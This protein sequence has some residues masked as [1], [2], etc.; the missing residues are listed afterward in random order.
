MGSI[1]KVGLEVEGG[2][3]GIPGINPFDD[4]ALVA[5]RSID[6][7]TL[8]A[9]HPLLALAHVGEAVSEPLPA[10]QEVI[11]KWIDKYW[12]TAA[13]NTCGYHIHI[14]L[15]SAGNYMRLTS[16]AFLYSL[17][18]KMK[19]IG[20][21]EGLPKTHYL[22]RRLNGANPFSMHHF[23]CSSQIRMARK[24]VGDRTR[25]GTLNFAWKIHGTV[26]FRA[27]P[28]FESKGLAKVFT[29]EYLEFVE[30][31][32]IENKNLFTETYSA[33]LHNRAG[34][35]GMSIGTEEVR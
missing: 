18:E 4:L 32:L 5:D 19:E 24:S 27:L 30:G 17:I 12:P 6:G 31:W 34:I 33:T 7:R 23:D 20:L 3:P 29:R 35:T 9:D 28:T 8:A 1:H 16:K 2:W 25:Y 14:S 10:D 22:W 11:D 26:E 15:K 13:N 21:R